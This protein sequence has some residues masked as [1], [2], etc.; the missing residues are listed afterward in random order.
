M[1]PEAVVLRAGAAALV[2]FPTGLLLIPVMIALARRLNFVAAPRKD[3]WGSRPTA[4]MGGVA[5]YAAASLA[6]FAAVPD[7][8]PL[9]GLYL[10][11]TAMFVVGLIDDIFTLGPHYK[12]LAQ[13]VA[14][15]I[16]VAFGVHF[17]FAGHPLFSIA[18]TLLFV[19]G[20]TN[21]I[22]LLDNMD[23]LAAGIALVSSLVLVAG[24]ALTGRPMSAITAGA[25]A[26]AL[27]A[28]LIFNF[29]PARVYMG[30]CGSLFLGL[31]LAGLAIRT[32]GSITTMSGAILFPA[33]V[34]A[35][36]IFDTAFVTIV[37]TINGR[38]I[39]EGGCDHTS[40][41]LVRLGLSEPQTVLLLCAASLLFGW[42][43]VLAMT[44]RSVA[45]FVTGALAAA[46]LL[47]SGHVLAQ[48]RVYQ[49]PEGAQPPDEPSA[50]DPVR[51]YKK[52]FAAALVDVLL[53]VAAFLAAVE[54]LRVSGIGDIR[55]TLMITSPAAI[56][57]AAVGMGV[58]GV[59]RDVR[60]GLWKRLLMRLAAGAAIA[61]AA[62]FAACALVT[63]VELAAVLCLLYCTLLLALC[64]SVRGLYRI[65]G[66]AIVRANSVQPGPVDGGEPPLEPQTQEGTV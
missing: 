48:V 62:S 18:L 28:F 33:I 23:G 1:T 5:I 66:D 22:N 49:D 19:V 58:A 42:L 24:G 59:Y 7:F 11:G 6:V 25:L 47:T 13:V 31:M 17:A 37:R 12:L 40:H 3:R 56:G 46:L 52:H 61:G 20:I 64:A 35:I 29:Y 26:G 43:G 45:L 21:A 54:A 15:C 51:L 32:S 41:R 2:A 8:R 57:G 36:P 16:L 53:A 38:A 4:L 50:F 44:Y 39:S 60:A 55:H 9:A 14:A 10:A 27:L 30:D 34:L 63:G 65:A